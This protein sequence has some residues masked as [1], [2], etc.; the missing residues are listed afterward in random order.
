MSYRLLTTLDPPPPGF[1]LSKLTRKELMAG[2]VVV[3]S[4]RAGQLLQRYAGQL[5]RINGMFVI[6][7]IELQLEPVAER[8]WCA[9]VPTRM[10]PELALWLTPLMAALQRSQELEDRLTVVQRLLERRE[11]SL[12]E[13]SHDYQRVN[14][15]LLDKVT[16]LT[17][18]QQQIIQLNQV[19]ESRVQERTA[20]LEASLRQTQ[21]AQ[22]QL[23]QTEKLA[24]LGSMV[25]GVAHE[26]NTPLG[27]CVLAASSLEDT[28]D[29]LLEMVQSGVIRKQE[30]L[31][32]MESLKSGFELLTSNLNRGADLVG[33]FKQVA[34]DQSNDERRL[35]AFLELLEDTITAMSPR[36]KRLKCQV[37]YHCP[38]GVVLD[39]YPGDFSQILMNL[40][41]NSLV[42]GFQGGVEGRILIVAERCGD[43]LHMEY[44]DNGRGLSSE[45][46]TRLFEPFFTTNRE[47]GGTGLGMSIIHSLVCQRLGGQINLE[48]GGEAGVCFRIRVPLSSPH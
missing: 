45:A 27:N 37:E 28:V 35:F 20:D 36:L 43:E 32:H 16:D 5:S 10:L 8:L 21:Q 41:M 31:H 3:L 38:E 29:E 14:G 22:E 39:S 34:A 18:A 15:R 6:P 1:V 47:R 42:H 4:D 19:L 30:F 40:I 25:A 13:T 33:R 44:S 2:P 11:R 26:I 24:A 17:R 48:S 7:A 12:N 46:R 23:I 9:R